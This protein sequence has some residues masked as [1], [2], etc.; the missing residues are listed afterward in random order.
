MYDF[1][2]GIIQQLVTTAAGAAFVGISTMLGFYIKRA[3]DNLKKQSLKSD[4]ESFVR[5]AEQYPVFKEYDGK[6]RFETVF[7]KGMKSATENGISVSK[8]EMV[9]L[10]ESSVQKM[11]AENFNFYTG[12][13]DL[14]EEDT[15]ENENVG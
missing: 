13:L 10:V 1:W 9:I 6:Q 14:L 12:E 5:W 8:E 11:N 3:T 15:K 4:I 7:A 2:G